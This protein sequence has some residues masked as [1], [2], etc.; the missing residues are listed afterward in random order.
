MKGMFGKAMGYGKKGVGMGKKAVSGGI[1]YGKKGIAAVKGS[2]TI[3][4]ARRAG[5]A[6][7]NIASGMGAGVRSMGK[8]ARRVGRKVMKTPPNK[9]MS[10]LGRLSRDP[11][12]MR[13]LGKKIAKYGAAG[14]AGYYMGKD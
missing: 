14:A 7:M 8:S 4:K 5:S 12:K 13:K 1:S 11:K 9:L 2:K 6:G 3:K 10:S